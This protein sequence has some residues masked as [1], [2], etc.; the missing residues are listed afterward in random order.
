MPPHPAIKRG[1]KFDQVIEGASAIFMRDGFDGASVDEIARE[2]GV[3]KATLYSYFPDK[4]LLF[5]EVAQ[6]EIQRQAGLILDLDN[7]DAP[8]REVLTRIGRAFIDLILSPFGLSVM[9]V[10]VAE[11]ERFPQIGQ[12]FFD[13]G[14]KLMEDRMIAYFQ[15][16]EDRNELR[17]PNKPFAAHQF[18]ELCKADC[19]MPKLI[20][21]CSVC[22]DLGTDFI[23]DEAVAM[24]LARYGV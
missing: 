24:F 22:E 2:A 19:F 9:R 11:S 23:V 17:I 20:G 10:V 13:N 6:Q 14:P 5:L 1:R 4:R 15:I 7:V 18:I 8:A 16:A 21:C 12:T 3:S